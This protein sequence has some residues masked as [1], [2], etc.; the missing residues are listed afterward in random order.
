MFIGLGRLPTIRYA[1]LFD[2]NQIPLENRIRERQLYTQGALLRLVKGRRRKI[3]MKNYQ[4]DPAITIS[5]ISAVN[6]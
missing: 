3:E 6:N 5:K 2:E 1:P 4:C